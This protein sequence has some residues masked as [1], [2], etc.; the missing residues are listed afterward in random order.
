MACASQI[1]CLE[2]SLSVATNPQLFYPWVMY[3]LTV[4]I[5]EAFGLPKSSHMIVYL[6][7]I[8]RFLTG[9]CELINFKPKAHLSSLGT[10][11]HCLYRKAEGRCRLRRL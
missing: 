11:F 10:S 5:T 2:T 1:S 6:M 9:D 8:F 7:L 3:L 4:K